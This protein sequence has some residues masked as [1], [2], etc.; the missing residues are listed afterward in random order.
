MDVQWQS[1][2]RIAGTPSTHAPSPPVPAV[3]STSLDKTFSSALPR[4]TFP[5]SADRVE[6]TGVEIGRMGR[7]QTHTPAPP[8]GGVHEVARAKPPREGHVSSGW[9]GRI[10]KMLGFGKKEKEEKEKKRARRF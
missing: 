2:S 1:L 5:A 4:S 7:A 8:P 9:I 10:W 6:P 3:S